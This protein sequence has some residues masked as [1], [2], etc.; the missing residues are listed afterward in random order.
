MQVSSEL[1]SQIFSKYLI[2]ELLYQLNRFKWADNFSRHELVIEPWANGLWVKQAGLIS[3]HDLADALK[4]EA[5]AKAY[6]LSVQQIKQG[7]FLVSS[8]QNPNKNYFVQF[9]RG[10]GWN[11][12]CM[13]YKCWNNRM[14]E[15]LPQ[16]FQALNGK[17]FC[18]HI[19]AAHDFDVT[20][21]RR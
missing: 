18:H 11:C 16:L 1:Q 13:R 19:V 15:E 2:A 21:S 7:R 3:Y 10:L 8:S 14:S 12:N 9:N 20:I 6:N 4:Q 5:E 17:I